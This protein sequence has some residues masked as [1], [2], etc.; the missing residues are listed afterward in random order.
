LFVPFFDQDRILTI[1]AFFAAALIIGT[2]TMRL[3]TGC[4]LCAGLLPALPPLPGFS[5]PADAVPKKHIIDLTIDPAKPAFEGRARIEIE[6]RRPVSV[7]WVNA[8]DLI[9][10]EASVEANGRRYGARAESAGGEFIGVE[11]DAPLGPG[12]A[13]LSISYEGRLDEKSLAG[14]YRRKVG[15][16][17]YVFTTFTPIEA[18]RAFPCF[19]EPRFKTPWELTIHVPRGE[20]A[21]ANTRALREIEEPDG[22]T[23]VQFAPTEPLPAEIVAFAVGPFDIFEGKPAGRGTPV[24]V[25]TTKGQAAA[26]DAA[27]QIAVDVL[28]RLEAYTGI[29]YAFGKLDELAL[30]EGAYGAVENPGLITYLARRLLVPPGG[31]TAEKTRAIA[32][33]EAHELTHQWFGDLVTQAGWEDV[34]LSEGFANWLSAKIMDQD[35]PLARQRLSAVM[36]REHVM[37]VD[38]GPRTRPV[39]LAM[40]SREEM[41]DVYNPMVYE[42]GAAVLWM[43]EGWLGEERMREGLHAYLEQHR[44]G[45]ATTSDLAAALGE[46]AH[47]DPMPVLHAFLDQTGVPLIHGNVRCDTGT[48]PRIELERDISS[49]QSSLGRTSRQWSIPVCWKAGG[50]AHAS[51]AILSGAREEVALPQGTACPAWIYLNAGGT[52][53]YRTEWSGAQL[54]ELA[55]RGL[56][57]LTAAERLTLIYDLRALPQAGRMDA[58]PLL[59][60]LAH[61]PEPEIAKAAA[62]AMQGK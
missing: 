43:L 4:L 14:P 2:R 62:D 44:F 53:Y 49:L 55:N 36:D 23:A 34:W 51:C 17:W 21:F 16:D 40:N 42:K 12:V 59:T 30:P 24:R 38:A 47:I 50:I 5:L 31:E 27:A 20:K 54:I 25:I 56:G 61:D 19:D 28:P 18:R 29:P 3:I 13:T 15:D 46:A 41:R 11:L 58:S 33:L 10:K 1:T 57:E 45:N 52:G 32:A 26:G 6:L 22:M 37:A 8:K 35:Q 48:A 39:R 9:P 60:Q 7:I